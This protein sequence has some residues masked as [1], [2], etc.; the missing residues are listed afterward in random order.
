MRQKIVGVYDLGWEQVQLV[1]TE[2]ENGRY[3]YIP[4]KDSLPRMEIGGDVS[5]AGE[6]IGIVLHEATEMS[7]DRLRVRHIVIGSM[8]GGNSDI[9][10][11]YD[12]GIHQDACA[13]VGEF[14]AACLPDLAKAW[15][16]WLKKGK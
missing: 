1:L 5:S 11:F 7:L 13:R 16:K 4:E 9:R 12:H 10:F 6:L 8:G 2:G 3:L 15:K 14:L